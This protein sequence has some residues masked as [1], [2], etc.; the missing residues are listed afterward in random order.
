VEA[1]PRIDQGDA[2]IQELVATAFETDL[3]ALAAGPYHDV[4]GPVAEQNGAQSGYRRK[5]ITS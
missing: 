1:S 3:P 2:V 4:I 5:G